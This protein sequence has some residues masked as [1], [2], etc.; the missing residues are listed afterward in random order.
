MPMNKGEYPVNWLEISLRIRFERAQNRCE[1]VGECGRDHEAEIRT[2]PSG[3]LLKIGVDK[4]TT[5][6]PAINTHNHPISGSRVVLTVAHLDH[7]PS[8]SADT[9]LLAMCQRCHLKYDEAHHQRNAAKTRY[10]AK[11]STGQ[12]ELL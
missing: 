3:K 2:L 6:C 5:R 10:Q 11:I 12:Q 9:N 8:N 7:D 1:C 4:V